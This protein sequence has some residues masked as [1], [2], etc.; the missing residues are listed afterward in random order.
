M[1]RFLSAIRRAADIDLLADILAFVS[2]ILFVV[3]VLGFAAETS[4]AVIALR[5]A[6]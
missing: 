3:V 2:M 1:S 5:L 6:Q 4:D